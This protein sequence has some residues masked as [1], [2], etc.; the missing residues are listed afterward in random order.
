[1]DP[2]SIVNA[3]RKN[4]ILVILHVTLGTLLGLGVGLLTPDT[5]TSTASASVGVE[6][7]SGSQ[8]AASVQNY[9]SSIIPTLVEVGTSESTLNQ[10]SQTTG[11]SPSELKSA[12]SVST[13]TDTVIIEVTATH[14]D[15][16]QAQA[17]AEA[18]M[19]ALDSA[20][21]TVFNP[22]QDSD[23]TLTLST[24]NS[25]TLP[26]EPSSLSTFWTSVIGGAAGLGI[27]TVM[28][29]LFDIFNRTSPRVTG[30]D[31]SLTP[32]EHG[33]AAGS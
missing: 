28:A 17:I 23:L 21:R 2:E 26:S 33:P 20:A 22:G 29:I 10:V 19:S 31:G 14:T 32:V 8:S 3:L 1:M 9:I 5:Y 7:S 27:G 25:P 6:Q 16:A 24:L 4:V 13:K 15:P 12:V 11:V 18:E 30:G